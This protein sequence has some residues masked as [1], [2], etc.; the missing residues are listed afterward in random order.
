MSQAA[1]LARTVGECLEKSDAPLLAAGYLT[2]FEK[3][4]KLNGEIYK[5]KAKQSVGET[6]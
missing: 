4:D 6:R 5:T 3:H 2:V 1:V